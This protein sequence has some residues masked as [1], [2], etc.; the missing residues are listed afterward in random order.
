RDRY[1]VRVRFARACLWT[2]LVQMPLM[3]GWVGWVHVD[4]YGW[5]SGDL[6]GWI[7]ALLLAVYALSG[8]WLRYYAGDAR[9]GLTE[10]TRLLATFDAPASVGGASDASDH[11]MA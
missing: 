7:A 2:T 9:R 4:V 11:T 6:Y 10:M 8:M 3:F 1:R 5:T